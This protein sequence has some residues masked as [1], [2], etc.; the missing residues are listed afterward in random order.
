MHERDVDDCRETPVHTFEV[1]D[2][3]YAY[4]P[5]LGIARLH[6]YVVI[7]FE[8]RDRVVCRSDADATVW[9]AVES[10]ILWTDLHKRVSE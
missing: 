9:V 5:T 4:D 3:V 8:G 10:S 7:G 2:R 1:G 6:Y